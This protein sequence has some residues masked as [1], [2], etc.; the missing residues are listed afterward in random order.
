MLCANLISIELNKLFFIDSTRNSSD[1]TF[2]Q[3]TFGHQG[4]VL[5]IRFGNIRRSSQPVEPL[6]W[7]KFWNGQLHD[8]QDINGDRFM[9]IG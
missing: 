5:L 8:F 1:V 9:E 6:V 2:E 7:G 4:T 3:I